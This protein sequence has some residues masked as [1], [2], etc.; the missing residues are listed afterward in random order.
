MADVEMNGKSKDLSWAAKSVE[1]WNI[2]VT[3]LHEEATE[4]DVQDF[5]ADFGSIKQV[6]MPLNR[7]TGYVMGYAIIEYNDRENAERAIAEA[8]GT[9]FLEQTIHV[10]FA[11]AKAPQGGAQRREGKAREL[12]PSRR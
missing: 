1:G 4:D 6:N 8:D 10:T 12:S 11:F 3:G 2:F 7:R 9:T 5:F